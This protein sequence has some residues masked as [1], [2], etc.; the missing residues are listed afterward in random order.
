MQSNLVAVSE[1]TEKK[2]IRKSRKN[3]HRTHQSTL[4]QKKKKTECNRVPDETKNLED[5][6]CKLDTDYLLV[7]LGFFK[8]LLVV[9]LLILGV[10]LISV[11]SAAVAP[12]G[13]APTVLPDVP[14]LVDVTM[15]NKGAFGETPQSAR[16]DPTETTY[17]IQSIGNESLAP[18]W[19][20]IML[21]TSAAS[22]FIAVRKRRG[23][24]IVVYMLVSTVAFVACILCIEYDRLEI[25]RINESP[26][27]DKLQL[28]FRLYLSCVI[29]ASTGV[30]TG[31][32]TIYVGTRMAALEQHRLYMEREGLEPILKKKDNM[33]P[34]TLI[35][36]AR[37]FNCIGDIDSLV[38]YDYE[39]EST[40]HNESAENKT[41]P[42]TTS[43][44]GRKVPGS[45][46]VRPA[47]NN[48]VS[49]V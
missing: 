39:G 17:E 34:L 42:S 6:V 30:A 2:H 33:F 13:A 14:L 10:I 3:N 47:S 9:P 48:Q 38:S 44:S 11:R 19:T 18:V 23:S 26:F 12:L 7:F 41:P 22:D 31:G 49:N 46:D 40:V 15:V 43:E 27:R 16:N 24:T 45:S 4:L 32:L 35:N 37:R 28:H 25:L 36:L 29:I 20:A 5:T 21:A 8:L 1:L